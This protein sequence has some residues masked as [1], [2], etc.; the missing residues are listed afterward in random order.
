MTTTILVG[1]PDKSKSQRYGASIIVACHHI[2]VL[3]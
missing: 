2:Y 3:L 1:G